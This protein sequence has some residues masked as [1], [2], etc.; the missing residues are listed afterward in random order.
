[1][2]YITRQEDLEQ[3]ILGKNKKDLKKMRYFLEMLFFILF[4]NYVI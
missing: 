3:K 1:M 2:C 4:I